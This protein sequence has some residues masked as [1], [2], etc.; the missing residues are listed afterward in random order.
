MP[1]TSTLAAGE[2]ISWN[3]V[4][5]RPETSLREAIRLMLDGG[6]S[7]MPVVIETGAAIDMLAERAIKRVP[8]L[9]DLDILAAM[10]QRQLVKEAF[11]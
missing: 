7:G 10:A 8:V 9:R 6:F 1:K 3:V 4:S 11:T 5:V 2:M